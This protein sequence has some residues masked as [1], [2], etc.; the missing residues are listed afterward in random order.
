[1]FFRPKI[2]REGPWGALGALEG[3]IPLNFF[4]YFPSYF[5][6]L[7]PIFEPLGPYF[8]FFPPLG[9]PYFSFYTAVVSPLLALFGLLP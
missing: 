9:A 2:V 3:P 1:M 8:P 7:G 6:P 5:P 4:P